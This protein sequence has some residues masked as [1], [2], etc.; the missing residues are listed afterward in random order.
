MG[1]SFV[2]KGVMKLIEVKFS[3]ELTKNGVQK[4]IYAKTGERNSRKA[5]I[6]LTENGEVFNPE[7]YRVR[8]TFDDGTHS[9][10]LNVIN[11]CVEFVLPDGLVDSEGER[12]CELRISTD[13]SVLYSPVFRV[14]V[15]GSLGKESNDVPVG[16]KTPY[17]EVIPYLPEGDSIS[18]DDEIAVYTPETDLTTKRKVSSLPF[19]KKLGNE[20]VLERIDESDVEELKR[21]SE[22]EYA[23]AESIPTKV[24]QLENDEDY[25]KATTVN[26]MIDKALDDVGGLTEEQASALEAN[27]KA[28]HSHSNKTVLDE[29]AVNANNELMFKGN[30]VAS[31]GGSST[32]LDARLIAAQTVVALL[33]STVLENGCT[34]YISTESVEAANRPESEFQNGM[35]NLVS[36]VLFNGT[37]LIY[38]PSDN[39]VVEYNGTTFEVQTG[40]IYIFYVD[41][42]S[43]EITFTSRYGAGI[44]ELLINGLNM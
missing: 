2:F 33:E 37:V 38:S 29:F 26:S 40:T 17:Q 44:R 22:G 39:G 4:S 10:D 32:P 8:V 34:A 43:Y 31:Q 13:T 7:G 25:V 6:T 14:M 24:S 21:L 23:A 36:P 42:E 1:S 12:L 27:T 5:V 11:G 30:P 41:E 20:A 15:E 3:L 28:R 16:S 18:A 19:G 35:S 9:G